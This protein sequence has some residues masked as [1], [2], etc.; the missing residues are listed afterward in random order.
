[1]ASTSSLNLCILSP[2]PAIHDL[3]TGVYRPSS[4]IENIGP[5]ISRI[6]KALTRNYQLSGS[7][8]INV[9]LVY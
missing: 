1:M 8:E 2:E 3:H 4:D 6:V 7:R 9:D 5:S